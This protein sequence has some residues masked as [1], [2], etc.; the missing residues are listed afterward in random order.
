MT[1]KSGKCCSVHHPSE[2]GL[3]LYRWE[4]TRKKSKCLSLQPQP[5]E[6]TTG[7]ILR[8]FV[9]QSLLCDTRGRSGDLC[10]GPSSV[11]STDISL[12]FPLT[13]RSAWVL[14]C[15]LVI[16]TY[17]VL[18]GPCSWTARLW[19]GFGQ[20]QPG[21]VLKLWFSVAVHRY[22]GADWLR[23]WLPACC[24]P[25]VH[26]SHRHSKQLGPGGVSIPGQVAQHEEGQ[27]KPAEI[28]G[29]WEGSLCRP[30]TWEE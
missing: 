14:G 17:G 29:L 7:E 20:W 5:F 9:L 21:I 25:Q 13:L 27:L 30:R 15:G 26:T 28:W 3:L 23:V 10:Q 4:K 8:A 1:G 2:D 6:I 19:K 12:W 24:L 11:S 16:W 22:Q 18:C